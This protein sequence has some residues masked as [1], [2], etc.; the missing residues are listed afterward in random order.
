MHGRILLARAILVASALAAMS[1]AWA[2]EAYPAR[3]IRLILPV[4]PGGG[5]DTTARAVSQK[6][7]ENLGQSII[8]DARPGSGGRA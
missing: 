8:V 6:V 3:P 2:G 5:Q 1:P 7:T 4:A